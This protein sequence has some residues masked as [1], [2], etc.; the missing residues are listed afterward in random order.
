MLNIIFRAFFDFTNALWLPFIDNGL[1]D[2]IQDILDMISSYQQDLTSLLNLL[3]FIVGK[4]YVLMFLGCVS[5]MVI[6][7]VVMSIINLI[8]P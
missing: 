4:Y 1:T 3:Y 8:Y 2:L 6:F 5:V 7:S